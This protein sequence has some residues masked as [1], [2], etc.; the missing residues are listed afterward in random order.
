MG[1]GEGRAGGTRVGGSGVLDGEIDEEDGEGWIA[2]VTRLA[3]SVWARRAT[4][5]WVA[6]SI[7]LFVQKKH[8]EV[9]LAMELSEFLAICPLLLSA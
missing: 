4:E 9:D 6:S 7:C 5:S 1:V 2:E 8:L 3:A